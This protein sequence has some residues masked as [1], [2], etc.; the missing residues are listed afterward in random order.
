MPERLA[1]GIEPL[2]AR[3]ELGAVVALGRLVG[4]RV[5]EAA[6]RLL[7]LGLETR[8]LDLDPGRALRRLVGALPHLDLGGTEAAQLLAE[9]GGALRTG[10]DTGP[11]GRLEARGEQT[12][13]LEPGAEGADGVEEPCE[14]VRVERRS[15]RRALEQ[16]RVG[17]AGTVGGSPRLGRGLLREREQRRGLGRELLARRRLLRRKLV[18]AAAEPRHDDLGRLRPRDGV[19]RLAGRVGLERRQAPQLGPE[20]ARLLGAD[21]EARCK[22]LL[23]A[24]RGVARRDR[25][26]SPRPV[27]RSTSRPRKRR[28]DVALAE[29]RDGRERLLGRRGGPGG[30]VRGVR[31]GCGPAGELLGLVGER[32]TARV[33]LEQHRL[34]RLAR[35]PEL[36]ALGVVAVALGRDHRSVGRVEQ[37]LGRNEPDTVEQAQSGRVARCELA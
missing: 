20:L 24:R 1:A 15:S 30:L 25:G 27:A 9:A 16:R 36:A 31:R 7:G 12:G 37:A 4:A 23:E 8:Q 5:V 34:G 17:G 32:A 35:E 6:P 21:R 33:H 11:N 3:G 14:H 10:V 22:R 26:P 28:I 13:A 2:R 18:E 29:V 19:G